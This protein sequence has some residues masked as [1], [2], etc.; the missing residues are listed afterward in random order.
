MNTSDA[1]S[2]EETK[3]FHFPSYFGDDFAYSNPSHTF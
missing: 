1:H 2:H 3:V